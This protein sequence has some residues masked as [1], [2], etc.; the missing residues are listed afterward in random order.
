MVGG[1]VL[2]EARR[3]A[4][5]LASVVDEPLP[6][7][8]DAPAPDLE[9][10]PAEAEI[11]V[12]PSWQLPETELAPEVPASWGVAA[13]VPPIAPAPPGE[14]PADASDPAPARLRLA[15]DPDWASAPRVAVAEPWR[16]WSG[17]A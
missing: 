5:L 2:D 11:E 8:S 17:A 14:A 6:V 10:A 13:S 7:S 9:P 15:P 4:A 12:A 3:F 1:L 16:R